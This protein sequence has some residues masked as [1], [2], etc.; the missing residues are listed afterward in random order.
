[1]S[2]IATALRRDQSAESDGP[3]RVLVMVDVPDRNE[4]AELAYQLWVNRGCPE[5]S[6][7]QDWLRA[8]EELLHIRV[9]RRRP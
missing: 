8:E 2:K 9:S 7:D 5:G 1:M 6:P 4:I 3:S